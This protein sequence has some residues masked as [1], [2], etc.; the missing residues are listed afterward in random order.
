MTP[1][2][3]FLSRES[4]TRQ[5]IHTINKAEEGHVDLVI[6]GHLGNSGLEEPALGAVSEQVFRH[7]PCLFMV[8]K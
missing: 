4:F 2:K 1:D 8:T 7:A 3:G 5:V 6:V